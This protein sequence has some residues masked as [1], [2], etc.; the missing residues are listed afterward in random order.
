MTAIKHDIE[1]RRQGGKEFLALFNNKLSTKK[2]IP[3]IFWLQERVQVFFV[4]MF[5]CKLKKEK[6]NRNK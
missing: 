1:E 3:W 4:C 6:K 2:Y 5:R